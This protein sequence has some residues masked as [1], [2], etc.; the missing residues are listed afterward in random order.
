[1]TTQRPRAAASEASALASDSESSAPVGF[2]GE[3]R[4]MPRVRS[5]TPHST[6]AAVRAKP[7]SGRVRTTTG[8]APASLICSTMVGQPGACVT[9]SSP[10]PNSAI[11]AW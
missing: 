4:M 9:T 5:V 2:P 7:S 3:L 10:G 11:A 6:T 1:M 8:V